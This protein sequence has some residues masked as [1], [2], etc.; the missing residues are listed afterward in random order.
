M[1][2]LAR[3]SECESHH[4]SGASRVGR[5]NYTLVA[6]I[7]TAPGRLPVQIFVRKDP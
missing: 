6:Q 4:D 5:Q 7:Q 1:A 3:G 2:N